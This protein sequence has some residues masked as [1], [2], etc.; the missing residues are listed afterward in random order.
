M[1]WYFRLLLTSGLVMGVLTL[2]YLSLLPLLQK[3]YRAGTLYLISLIL[4]VGFLIP[5]RPQASAPAVTIY[6]P[7][8]LSQSVAGVQTALTFL[9]SSEPVTGA[10]AP[11]QW[12]EQPGETVEEEPAN[13]SQPYKAPSGDGAAVNL[14]SS[15]VGKASLESVPASSLSPTVWDILAVCWLVGIAAIFAFQAVHHHRFMRTVRRWQAAP[16]RE[17]TVHVFESLRQ[18]QCRKARVR[19]M[20]CP[21]IGTPMLV[22]LLRPVI[23]LPDEELC[24]EELAVV[25]T[26][27][28]THLRHRDLWAKAGLLLMTTLNWFNPAA[29]ML[30]RSATFSQE[31]S[32]DERVTAHA[33]HSDKLFYSETILR[34][35][36][37][38]TRLQTALTTSFCSGKKGMK[39]RITTIIA[40]GTRLGAALCGAV[41]ALTLLTGMAFGMGDMAQPAEEALG[42]PAL[43]LGQ[44]AYILNPE[45]EGTRMTIVPSAND[46]S[47]PH[48]VYFNG[49]PV[50]VLEL[51]EGGAI[52]SGWGL[53][54]GGVNWAQVSVGGDGVRQGMLGWIPVCFLS[55]AKPSGALPSVTLA[56]SESSGHINLYRSNA[57]ES[58]LL[59]LR[60]SGDSAAFL[61]RVGQWIHLEFADVSGFAPLGNVTYSEEVSAALD[62][63]LADGFDN[64]PYE[65]YQALILMDQLFEEKAKL[66][67]STNVDTWPPE[68]KAWYSEL[69]STYGGGFDDRQYLL[70]SEGDLQESQAA[71]I[72]WNAFVEAN[73]IE[74]GAREAYDMTMVGFYTLYIDPLE[75]KQWEVDITPKSSD[76]HS[77]TVVISSPGGDVLSAGLE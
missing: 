1:T 3:R 74:P 24:G 18:Q 6:A 70:P 39:R 71:D 65:E 31:T 38:Q 25:L 40:G 55:S 68:G 41:L 45:A 4:A 49:T 11:G 56:T 9:T 67:Q 17:E 5:F 62:T 73:A 61:G 29:W 64:I 48:A 47:C 63:F 2:V 13:G 20:I 75:G 8:A 16:K 33:N 69:T 58:G 28:L 37:R 12:V 54:A 15:P 30:L 27:E 50:T 10:G 76:T 59:S 23:L 72:A 21:S 26:H 36:Q 7:A 32:C 66:Y 22:G 77:F 35:I 34:V 42:N 53:E 46:W 44:T 57:E 19:L 51:S 14:A 60:Q 52:L 43:A